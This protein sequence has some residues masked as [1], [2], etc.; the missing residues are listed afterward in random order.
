MGCCCEWRAPPQLRYALP[1]IVFLLIAYLYSAFVLFAHPL[2]LAAGAPW[3]EFA[4]FQIL[5][6]LLCWSLA[7]CLLSNDSFVR[8]NGLRKIDPEQLK[9]GE[10]TVETKFDGGRRI[11]RKCRA[12][13][14][15]RAHHCSTC[16]RCVLKMDH[17]CVY[18]NK[19][20]S[21][22]G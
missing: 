12:L 14:P 8:R 13:K 5:F 11:C 9:L 3:A 16:N 1:A 15:D 17:H 4:L 19:Y 20:V 2:L 10:A 21:F 7:Q 6:A 22:S 18:I